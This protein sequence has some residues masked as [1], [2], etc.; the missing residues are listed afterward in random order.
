VIDVNELVNLIGDLFGLLVLVVVFRNRELPRYGI[1][2]AGLGA[3]ILSHTFTILE[4][5]ALRRFFDVAEHVSMLVAAAL[6]L[7]G[8]IRYFGLTGVRDK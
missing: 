4:E 3:I 5:F 2:L 6:F 8:A 1:F 7:V